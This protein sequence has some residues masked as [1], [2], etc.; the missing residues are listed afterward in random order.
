[1]KDKKEK[2][3]Y[4]QLKATESKQF[5]MTKDEIVNKMHIQS[6]KLDAYS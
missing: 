1:M 5:E 4:D 6:K 3:T 2:P